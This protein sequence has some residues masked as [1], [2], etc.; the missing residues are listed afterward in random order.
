MRIK[1]LI[2]A[3]MVLVALPVLSQDIYKIDT[4]GST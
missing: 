2:P 1:A 3:L 4:T